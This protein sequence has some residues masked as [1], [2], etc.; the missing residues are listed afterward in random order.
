M[1]EHCYQSMASKI[2][3][4]QLAKEMLK[5]PKGIFFLSFLTV[6][7]LKTVQIQ[8]KFQY[9]TCQLLIFFLKTKQT[10]KPT[11]HIKACALIVN[12]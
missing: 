6:I 7:K 3:C 4:R 9:Q 12:S 10:N 11:T 8:S 1:H 2:H 5:C